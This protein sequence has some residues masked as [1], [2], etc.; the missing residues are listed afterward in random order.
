MIQYIKD[1][2]KY[3]ML[4]PS[5]S[6]FTDVSIREFGRVVEAQQSLCAKGIHKWDYQY[7]TGD[8]KQ[9][10]SQVSKCVCGKWAVRHYGQSDMTI[11]KE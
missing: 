2:L 4:Y 7:S 1:F 11:I 5:R 10:K 8:P 3:I 9:G 6:R